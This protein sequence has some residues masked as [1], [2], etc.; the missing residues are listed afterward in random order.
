MSEMQPDNSAELLRKLRSQNANLQEENFSLKGKIKSLN[1]KIKKLKMPNSYT[2]GD[3]NHETLAELMA[4]VPLGQIREVYSQK[5]F[6]SFFAVRFL[7]S[8]DEDGEFIDGDEINTFD[9]EQEAMAFVASLKDS[10]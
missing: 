10:K 5:Q 6:P 2:F 8:E 1:A 9:T 3:S 4:D 7:I